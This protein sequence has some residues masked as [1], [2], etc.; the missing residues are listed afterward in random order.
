[1]DCKAHV[2]LFLG[3]AYYWGALILGCIQYHNNVCSLFSAR[4]WTEEHATMES[5]RTRVPVLRAIPDLTVSTVSIR[6]T[7]WP[8]STRE[9]VLIWMARTNV[10]VLSGS[11]DP[12]VRYV[13]DLYM[14]SGCHLYLI[15]FFFV[16]LVVLKK[17]GFHG[18][19]VTV[20]SDLIYEYHC[21][22]DSW[23]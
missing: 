13:M 21:L 17:P 11:P 9:L 14:Y 18:Q 19:Q 15:F 23:Y 20:Y 16:D 1:M 5:T 10:I 2:R 12:G 3:C 8:A 6:V 7:R 22:I 4:V